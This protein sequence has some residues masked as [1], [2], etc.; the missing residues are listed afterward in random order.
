MSVGPGHGLQP[1][2]H[3]TEYFRAV[4]A[5]GFGRVLPVATQRWISRKL[6][7]PGRWAAV[8]GSVCT[9][10]LPA[11]LLAVPGLRVTTGEATGWVAAY[12]LLSSLMLLAAWHT[13]RLLYESADAIDDLLRPSPEEHAN[14]AA[15]LRDAM[16]QAKQLIWAVAGAAVAV[17]IFASVAP[18]VSRSVEL[19]PIS[20][21]VVAWTGAIGGLVNYW[22]IVMA[23]LPRR[24]RACRQLDLLEH[25]PG[26]TRAVVAGCRGWRFVAAAMLA[27]VALTEALAFLVPNKNDEP[28]LHWLAI[29]FPIV[30]VLEAIYVAVSP[31]WVMHGLVQNARARALRKYEDLA[32]RALLGGNQPAFLEAATIYEIV[33]RSP[34]LPI[35]T[36]AVIEY[37]AALIGSIL[38]FLLQQF[39]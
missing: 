19:Q 26:T 2:Q 4:V 27:G 22:L 18:A 25:S 15:W 7:G 35:R 6:F 28:I 5:E 30:V 24:L 8:L 20:Y 10:F 16:S 31:F 38:P 23:G 39:L 3:V 17:V 34:T 37:T 29:I 33:W 36:G 12:L 21:I 1:D 11:V 32:R 9:G 14:I 13:W